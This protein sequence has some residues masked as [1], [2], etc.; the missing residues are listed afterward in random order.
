MFS[1]CV[2]VYNVDRSVFFR[3]YVEGEVIRITFMEIQY[4][5]F[6]SV[7]VFRHSC[8]HYH[9][10]DGNKDVADTNYALD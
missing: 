4:F 8:F 2:C 3:M 9:R 7:C 6:Q 1:E 10:S 5:V